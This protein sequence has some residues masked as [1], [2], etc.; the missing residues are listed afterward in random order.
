MPG[1]LAPAPMAPTVSEPSS[2]MR[3]MRTSGRRRVF[4][5]MLRVEA[6]KRKHSKTAVSE[7]VSRFSSAADAEIPSDPT[8]A[9]SGAVGIDCQDRGGMVQGNGIH[10][11]RIPDRAETG[12]AP[13]RRGPVTTTSDHGAGQTHGREPVR[14]AGLARAE[15]AAC[16]TR[17]RQRRETIHWLS[18]QQS[19]ERILVLR[20]P[21]D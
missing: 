11:D 6:E 12:G 16:R 8:S 14:L 10:R 9:P 13:S 20:V 17:A 5:D 21:G 3:Q 4:A 18:E 15:R 19:R 7:N 2:E 1:R